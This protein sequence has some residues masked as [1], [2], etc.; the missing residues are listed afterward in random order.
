M[1]SFVHADGR[2]VAPLID[3]LME[4]EAE[5]E[6]LRSKPTCFFIV[7]SPGVGK[8]TLA[9]K[10]AQVWNCVLIDDTELLTYHINNFTEHGLKLRDILNSGS[11]IPE[12]TV[13]QLIME[14][15]RSP[16]V[17][18]HGYVLSCLPSISEDYLK[19]P[20]QIEIIKN[21]KFPPDFII[22]IKCA[23]RDLVQRLSGRRLHPETGAVYPREQ[24]NVVKKETGR[25]QERDEMEDLGEEEEKE[26]NLAEK[27]GEEMEKQDLPEDVITQ[28]VQL[29]EDFPEDVYKKILLY[30]DTVLRPLQDYMVNHD[31]LF[32]FELD[33]NNSSEDLFLLVVSRLESMAARRAPVPVQLLQEEE[34]EEE[35][36]Q[37]SVDT[38]KLLRDLSACKPVAPGLRW[39]QSR[40]GCFC[41][42]A[43]REG[44]ILQGKPKFAIRFLDKMYV[45]SSSEALQKFMVNPRPYLLPPM[46]RPPCKV[47]VIGPPS[48]G[49][50]TLCG[51]IASHYG[52]AVVDVEALVRPTLNQ[53]R[54]TMLEKVRAEATPIAIQRV[55]ARLK[56]EVT[57]V[58]NKASYKTEEEDELDEN[59]ADLTEKME[60]C[61]VE[62]T[63]QH[64]E[65]EALVMEALKEAE[66]D[67]SSPR[68]D[69]YGEILTEHIKEVQSTNSEGQIKKGWVIDNYP[70]NQNQLA[71]LQDLEIRPDTIIC[72][73]DGSEDAGTL[74]RRIYEAHRDEVD[75]VILKRLQEKQRLEEQESQEATQHRDGSEEELQLTDS[76]WG[77]DSVP[78]ETQELKLPQV[79]E[80]GYPDCPEM[81][82]FRL[83]VKQFMLEWAAMESSVMGS[84]AVLDIREKTP[85]DLLREAVAIMERPFQYV[86]W[87]VTSADLDEEEE[88]AQALADTRNADVVEAETETE[89]GTSSP[90]RIMGDTL[91]FC[92]VVL[93]ERGTLFP[94]A[95]DYAVKYRE[96]TYYFSSTDAKDKFLQSPEL[97]VSQHH[98]LQAPALRIFLLGVRGSGKT[99]QTKWL[100]KRLNIFHIQFRERLQELLVGKT[101][102][103]VPY[104]DEMEPADEWVADLELE[105]VQGTGENSQ[106]RAQ[107]VLTEEEE[108]IR[109]CLSDGVPLPAEILDTILPQWWEQEPYKSAGFILEGFPQSLE[110][111]QYLMDHCLLP[112]ATVVMEVETAD[113]LRRL[114]PQRLDRWRER[115]MRKLERQRKAMELRLRAREE[116]MA[117]R[118]AE[119][120]AERAAGQ[121][122]ARMD[123][124]NHSD[125][126]PEEV[127]AEE[128][129]ESRVEAMLLDEFPPEEEGEDEEEETEASAKEHL[130]M[131]I[132]DCFETDHT[133]LQKIMEALTDVRNLQITIRAGRTPQIVRRQL[134]DKLRALV[135]KREALFEICQPLGCSLAH[136]MLHLSYKFYSGFGYWDPVKLSEG[137]LIQSA[138]GPSDP[139]FPVLFHQFIYFF[140]SKETRRKFMFNPIK[141]LRQP[142]PRPPLPIKMAITGPPKSGKSTVARKFASEFG[143]QRLSIGDAMRAVLTNQRQTELVAHMLSYLHQGLA[144]PDKLAVQCLEVALMNLVCSTRGFILDGFPVTKGQ[145]DLMESRGIVPYRVVELQVDTQESL[146]RGLVDQMKIPRPYVM[147]D[148]P[149]ALS[150]HSSCYRR[151]VEPVRQH[152][153]EQHQN[154]VLVDGHKSKW[155]V[156][157]KVLEEAQASVRHIQGYLERKRQGRAA[158][159]DRLLVTPT[160]MQ[161]RLGEF[162]QY[163]PVSLALRAELVDCSHLASLEL[164]AEFQGHYYKMAS[165]DFLKK[166][167]ETP[168]RY[169]TPG[170]P[171]VIPPTPLLP[172]RLTA[173]QLK[174][175]FPQQA[176]M[177][178]Y[179]PV[180]YLDGRQRYEALVRGHPDYAAEYR[181][182]IHIFADEEKLQKFLRSPETYWDQ[183]LP[184]KLPP[185]EAPIT[186]TSLPMLGYLEQGVATAIITAMTAVGCFKPK[187]PYLSAKRSAL[188]YVAYHLKAF[189]PRNSDYICKKYK[190]KLECLE[191]GCELIS[192]LGSTMTQEYAQTHEQPVDF[193]HKL[194][195]FL[196]LKHIRVTAEGIV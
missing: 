36:L 141:Y 162:G 79:W 157:C 98:R 111:V 105:A 78:E 153:Q 186:L 155:W 5:R 117:R 90:K 75:A 114:L 74:L 125:E 88:D 86:A 127:E 46:P 8:S 92:P 20:E 29:V 130:E 67:A 41:P 17:E 109:C 136:K 73:K 150:V 49:K 13:F 154:W 116:A 81:D 71:A 149:Q 129:L 43:L 7:G 63:E 131:E 181:E 40:W 96:K 106:S 47:A 30:K 16:E 77:L 59:E 55:K 72:L 39:R 119:I 21:F 52:A 95:D 184:H 87:E 3:S 83:G 175:R 10:I 102:E 89:E 145:V 82:S 31:P 54:D 4:D 115:R 159:I 18:H 100:A 148:S 27:D 179:C 113:V 191:D 19:I 76:H 170:C 107:V 65:V 122:A 6:L 61:E 183:K 152:Y 60:S 94:C 134:H 135:E 101:V 126:D 189:N 118:R 84:C 166:F 53:A 180:T 140:T 32:L 142:K 163:C 93:K 123:D 1:C 165:K 108:A 172:K 194:Q 33:G 22:N 167:L 174:A 171:R 28:L 57:H 151:E 56:A 110:D 143:I 146:R 147:H 50:S 121:L 14:R 103:R 124:E 99:S 160:E 91:H 11:C 48:V 164:V 68:L 144:V 178:G 45:L 195:R 158:C 34:E 177:K 138:R 139:S 69:V 169:V 37:A 176:E 128:E 25:R 24:W 80:K 185:I 132:R 182:K 70:R 192:Y 9:R 173:L 85:E 26:D 112:D 156:W 66:R 187:Y 161:A 120:I 35:I 23:D 188:L 2:D 133:N 196:A 97:Y 190:K 193:T 44:T 168:Q 38:D 42:V 58:T 15:L 104:A 62:V 64:P 12:E 137:D 51:L